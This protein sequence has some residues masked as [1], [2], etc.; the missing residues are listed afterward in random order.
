MPV[1]YAEANSEEARAMK[2]QSWTQVERGWGDAA[3]DGLLAGVVAGLVMAAYV[4][5]V[6]MLRGADW[7]TVLSQ[8]DPGAAPRALNGA[9]THLAVA[10]VYGALF[11]LT[12]RAVARLVRRVPAWAAGLAYGLLLWG[13]AALITGSGATGGWLRDMPPLHFAVAHAIYGL[14]LGVGAA[15]RART[16]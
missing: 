15:R 11:G 16:G 8:F 9:L 5:V 12:W 7:Q 2:T 10:G 13:L 4:L 1:R 3:V 6:G 14:A